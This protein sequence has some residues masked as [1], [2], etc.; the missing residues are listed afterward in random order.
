MG[1][2]SGIG[3]LVG[4]LAG[5]FGGNSMPQAPPGFNMPNMTGAANNAF[6]GIGGLS[7]FSNQGFNIMGQGQNI[8]GNLQ[9]NPYAQFFQS[10]AGQAAGLGQLQA[11]GQYGVGQGLTQQGQNLFNLGGSIYQNAFDPQNQLYGYLQGQN[12]QQS[13]V[14]AAAAGLATTPYGVGTTN[15]SNQLFNLGW[16]N[17]QLG[18]EIQGA[19]AIGGL[20]QTGAGLQ[21]VGQGLQASAPGQYLTASGMPY[22]VFQGMGQDQFSNLTSLLNASTGG[23]NL[24]NL[25][26]QDYL[27]YLQAGNQANS[28][29]N[30]L[31]GLQL[32]AQNQQFNQ[33]R[34]LGAGIG[35]GLY[36][37]GSGMSG[38]LS[39][40]FL[41][42]IFGGGGGGSGT[43]GYNN[44][45]PGV[46]GPQ[47][48]GPSGFY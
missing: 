15:Q 20:S 19:N 11:L 8:F 30:Q 21:Q 47:A 24:S 46:V 14:N 33:N 32:Q 1:I 5:L 45:M 12:T 29:S 18:R 17:N 35:S 42:S 7:P 3:G 41:G 48:Y 13:Q 28:V 23:A 38:G 22:N 43:I 44:G 36:N 26:I 16:Q 27:A 34:L 39:S 37:I 2:A 9:N 4:G 10:G 25:P 31:Y 6:S 40:P